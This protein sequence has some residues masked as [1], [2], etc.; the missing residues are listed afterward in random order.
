MSSLHA[1]PITATSPS[2]ETRQEDQVREYIGQFESF[3]RRFEAEWASERDSGP[4]GLDEGKYVLANGLDQVLSFRSQIVE[5]LD[6]VKQVL[7]DASKALR[8]LQRYQLILDGGRSFHQ[9]WSN[10]N[11][12]IE[13]LKTVPA[14]LRGA[15][16]E[17]AH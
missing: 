12:V 15:S 3:L 6:E 5:G 4:R 10:G 9:F 17:T 1:R 16:D 14:V 8:T 13:K 11:E 2:P 7:D